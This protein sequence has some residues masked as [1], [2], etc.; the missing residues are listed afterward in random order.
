MDGLPTACKKQVRS[1]AHL[2]HPEITHI[3][4]VC[5]S[6]MRRIRGKGAGPGEDRVRVLYCIPAPCSSRA[7][8]T[9]NNVQLIDQRRSSPYEWMWSDTGSRTGQSVNDFE[10]VRDPLGAFESG[11]P[12]VATEGHV[13]LVPCP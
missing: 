2:T 7:N 10:R 5:E 8:P 12:G 6:Q 3:H 1:R 13:D 11:G 9:H 4:V